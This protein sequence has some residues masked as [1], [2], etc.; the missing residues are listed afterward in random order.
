MTKPPFIIISGAPGAGKSTIARPLARHLGLPLFEKDPIKERLADCVGPSAASISPK[1]GLAAILQILDVA[2]EL[3]GHGVGVVIEST[4]Y[5]GISESDLAPLLP[6]SRPIN[7]HVTA[8]PTLIISR[9]EQRVRSTARHWI[10]NQG[11]H[12]SRIR[13]AIAN[14]NT[15][16]P[17]L[18]IPCI[19]VDTTETPVDTEELANSIRVQLDI[20]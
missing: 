17:N 3:L 5:R 6:W 1:L 12:V 11:D 19:L 13:D 15:Q 18:G 4:F 7:V 2:R 9:Y 14:G 16:P 8:D 20:E 10:H